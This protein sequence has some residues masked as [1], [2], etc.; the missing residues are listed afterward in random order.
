[1]FEGWG[2]S[3]D[4]WYVTGEASMV[5]GGYPVDYR[6]G[7]ID[8]LICRNAWPWPR[9]EEV[10][11]LMPD[12]GTKAH[13]EFEAF[14]KKH[15]KTP[16][17]HPLP[18]V[19][20]RAEDR[21]EHTYWLP[22]ESG[23]RVAYPWVQALHRKTIIEFYE[24]SSTLDL[25]VFDQKKFIRWKE[26][27]ETIQDY[28]RSIGD[29]KAI[30]ACQLAL[31]ACHRA[32]AFFDDDTYYD[33]KDGV[34]TGRSAYDGVVEGEVRHWETGEDFTGKIAVLTHLT[35]AQVTTLRHAAGI[36]TDQGGTLS[37]AAI[38]AREYKIPTLIGTGC[39]TR[40]FK[41]GDR[42]L[43]HTASGEARK[44]V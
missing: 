30:K 33:H 12:E 19:G 43:L 16:D 20:L 15:G 25:D 29:E 11:N 34:V 40:V 44:L 3:P 32:I 28:G 10:G 6:D 8:V 4:D 17:L 21:F 39:A 41:V 2:I 22:D 23:V 36:I 38:I 27:I 5:L 18:H 42:I 35:P 1:M 13:G 37:H 26:F 14:V 31:P 7:I 24:E 9:P